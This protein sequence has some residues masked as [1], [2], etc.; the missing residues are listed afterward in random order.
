MSDEMSDQEKAYFHQQWVHVRDT[1]VRE[2]IVGHYPRGT[3]ERKEQHE[4]N[5]AKWLSM[6]Q[7][8][9]TESNTKLAISFADYVA[10]H[11]AAL[12]RER[13][14]YR[15]L[16]NEVAVRMGRQWLEERAKGQGR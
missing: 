15:E 2:Y 13:A 3:L 5:Y 7:S 12:V 11:A 10:T 8:M 1:M 16:M 14:W 9:L 6:V 4:R